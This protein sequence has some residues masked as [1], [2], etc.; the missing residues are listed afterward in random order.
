M[1]TNRLLELIDSDE[2][3]K[4]LQ[5]N[6]IRGFVL[7]STEDEKKR[8]EDRDLIEQVAYVKNLAQVIV[9]TDEVKIYTIHG[10]DKWDIEYPYRSIF[11]NSEGKWERVN[12]VS[13]SLDLA[14]LCYIGQKQLGGNSQFVDFA[15]KMLGIKY[16][17]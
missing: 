16:E 12:I 11:L 13:P 3:L 6:I 10:K 7:R 8:R 4:G 14:F 5:K 15:M 2:E 1:N 9:S 17:E